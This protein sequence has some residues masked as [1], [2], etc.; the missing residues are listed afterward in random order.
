MLSKSVHAREAAARHQHTRAGD[1]RTE[2]LGASS[3]AVPIG[4]AVHRIW[5]CAV[6]E[7]QRQR[8]V[9]PLLRLAY[10]RACDDGTDDLAVWTRG[11]MPTQQAVRIAE[12]H[13]ESFRWIVQPADGWISGRIY[14][15]GSMVDGPPCLD[16]LCRRLGWAIVALDDDGNITASA[17]G[18]PAMW[19]DTVY[20]AELWALWQA[21]RLAMPGTSFRTDCLSVLKVFQS[22]RARCLQQPVQ[23]CSRLAWSLRLA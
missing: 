5:E 17:C 7:Q 23:A 2:T 20:G 4:T 18:A 22:G 9:S 6:T 21:A 12:E 10:Q 15:D 8:L 3:D 16:G 14:T 19:I 1:V 13:C 11:L